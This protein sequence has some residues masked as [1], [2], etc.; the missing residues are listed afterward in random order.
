[1]YVDMIEQAGHGPLLVDYGHRIS[2]N[3][4]LV[5]SEVVYVHPGND[6]GGA[7]NL[8]GGLAA[9]CPK[10]LL[11]LSFLPEETPVFCIPSQMPAYSSLVGERLTKTDPVKVH[12]SWNQLDLENL[13]SIEPRAKSIPHPYLWKDYVVGDSH[14][15]SLYR[16]K[17]SLKSVPYQTLHGALKLGLKTF[18]DYYHVKRVGF[19]FGNIDVRHHLMRQPDPNEATFK[20]VQEYINQAYDLVKQRDLHIDIYELLPIEDEARKIPKTGY[21]KGR[22]FW[23]SWTQRNFIRILFK[24]IARQLIKDLGDERIQLVEWTDYLLDDAGRLDFKHMEKPQSVHL[25]RA[26]WPYWQGPKEDTWTV[27]KF[28]T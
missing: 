17:T 13:A 22:P 11:E 9:E 25:A 10:A 15:I 26:S 4:G 18:I 21:Y 3:E 12:P 6:W 24:D 2:K 14:A 20:L 16:P 5:G 7:L 8:Y 23:G 19:Y 27:E 1:M 28:M